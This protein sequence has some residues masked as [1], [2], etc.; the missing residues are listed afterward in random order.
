MRAN[1][2]LF[3]FLALGVAVLA[4]PENTSPSSLN[5]VPAY[6]VTSP[7]AAHSF[8]E[9]VTDPNYMIYV[10]PAGFNLNQNALRSIRDM[11]QKKKLDWTRLYLA[12]VGT[13][14]NMEK[15]SY[16]VYGFPV[17]GKEYFGNRDLTPLTYRPVVVQGD[18]GMIPIDMMDASVTGQVDYKNPK[19]QTTYGGMPTVVGWQL[20]WSQEVMS[21]RIPLAPFGSQMPDFIDQVAKLKDKSSY[22]GTYFNVGSFDPRSG[23][24]QEAFEDVYNKHVL[25]DVGYYVLILFVQVP[26]K[27]FSLPQCY[28]LFTKERDGKISFN[29]TMAEKVRFDSLIKKLKKFGKIRVPQHFANAPFPGKQC[30]GPGRIGMNDQKILEDPR[31][32][33]E[34]PSPYKLFTHVICSPDHA[35]SNAADGFCKAYS[36]QISGN[37]ISATLDE[38]NGPKQL[39]VIQLPASG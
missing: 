26:T 6:F 15:V 1:I 39:A 12:R 35:V 27:S 11:I 38:G 5:R 21:L 17:H 25:N 19:V 7:F 3:A 22:D 18:S 20:P 34:V 31:K 37:Q 30:D 36:L 23:F 8:L 32:P 24:S 13:E 33:P 28:S 29:P 14:E 2:L 16:A 4:A 9:Y 10:Q